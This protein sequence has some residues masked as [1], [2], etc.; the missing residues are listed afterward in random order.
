M[1][2]LVQPGGVLMLITAIWPNAPQLQMYMPKD[3]LFSDFH[4][5]IHLPYCEVNM[6]YIYFWLAPGIFGQE[7]ETN[8]SSYEV[9]F[10]GLTSPEVSI[11]TPLYTCKYDIWPLNVPEV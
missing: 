6:I 1:V 8:L 4:I 11:Y 3:A 10:R 7:P 5:C 9:P 2:F